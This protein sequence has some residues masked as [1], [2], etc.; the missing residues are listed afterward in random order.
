M[1][2]SKFQA[3]KEVFLDCVFPKSCVGCSKSDTYLCERCKQK[4][5]T[6]QSPTCLGCG[7]LKPRG[8]YCKTCRPKVDLTG[9]VIAAHYEEGPLKE[10]I[11]TFKYDFVYDLYEELSTFLAEALIRNNFKKNYIVTYVPLHRSKENWRGF[12][13]SKLL[14]KKVSETLNFELIESVLEKKKN[15]KRQIELKKAE[16]FKNVEDTFQASAKYVDKVKGKR[17][18]L[19]DDVITTGAT[20]NECAKILRK[21]LGAKEVWGLVLGKH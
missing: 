19:V 21:K 4:I 8:K 16:R 1:V 9:V 3:A 15:T 2:N 10:A 5:V 11:H 7:K 17:I 14:A 13:Q 20:L 12:N 18:I 6:I